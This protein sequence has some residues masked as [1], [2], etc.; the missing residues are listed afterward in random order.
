MAAG[1]LFSSAPH[2]RRRARQVAA[3]GAAT[4]AGRVV[5]AEA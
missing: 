1:Q 5:A 3:H 2:T 4:L